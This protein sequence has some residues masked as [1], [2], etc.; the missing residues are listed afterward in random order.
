[1]HS[2]GKLTNRQSPLVQPAGSC[3]ELRCRDVLGT[4]GILSNGLLFDDFFGFFDFYDF[5]DFALPGV[6]AF[7]VLLARTLEQ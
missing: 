5:F 1:M 4:I 6:H 7:E 2:N 3:V